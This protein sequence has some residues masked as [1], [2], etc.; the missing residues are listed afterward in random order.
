MVKSLSRHTLISLE[1]YILIPYLNLKSKRGKPYLLY[2]ML[3]L[4]LGL[5]PF[6]FILM[7]K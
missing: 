4:L 3:R 2:K 5:L 7:A 1:D 6:L